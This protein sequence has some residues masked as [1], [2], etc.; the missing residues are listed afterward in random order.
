MAIR[1]YQGSVLFV[2][3]CL[4]LLAAE[5]RGNDLLLFLCRV[6]T[7]AQLF[8]DLVF[9][10][11]TARS[12]RMSQDRS[13]LIKDGIRLGASMRASESMATAL[14]PRARPRRRRSGMDSRSSSS[15]SSR[16]RLLRRSGSAASAAASGSIVTMISLS[17]SRGN[18][19]SRRLS[20]DDSPISFLIAAGRR[21]AQAAQP[22]RNQAIGWSNC[23]RLNLHAARLP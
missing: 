16:K 19:P 13:R 21:I 9:Q 2:Q 15:S 11:W 4:G 7:D 14:A 20:V 1:D 18:T 6:A 3:G 17:Y 8:A 10:G 22:Q 5:P 23:D 12:C